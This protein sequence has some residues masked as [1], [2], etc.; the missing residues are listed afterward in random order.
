MTSGS[1][2]AEMKGRKYKEI[3]CV[4]EIF[5]NLNSERNKSVANLAVSKYLIVN[6]AES[7]D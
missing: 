5:A 7:T 6:Q 3:S 1:S 4:S 2:D